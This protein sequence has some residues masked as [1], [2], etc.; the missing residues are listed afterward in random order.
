MR[1]KWLPIVLMVLG[2]AVLAADWWSAYPKGRTA[3]YVGRQACIQC[4]RQQV[5]QWTG[6]DHDLAMDRAG[7]ETIL[8]NFSDQEFTFNGITSRMYRN[9]EEF[10]ITTDGPSGE[11]ESFPIK[12]TFGVRPLQQ[13][14]S[15]FDDGRVQ[16]LSIAW[17][18]AAKRW[19]HLYPDEMI[20]HQDELH[21]T[22]PAQN[23][24]YMCAECH[25]TNLRKNYDPASDTYR[26]TFSEIDVSCEACHG[27]ASIHIE[28]ANSRSLFWD[29]RYGKGL[30][31]LKGKDSKAQLDTCARCHSRRHLIYEGYQPGDE[32]LDYYGLELLDGELYY[33]D[34]QIRDEVYVYGS[35]LQSRMYREGVR[36]TDC[37]DPHSTRLLAQGNDLCTQCH[38]AGS[39][40]TP[41][42]H[43]HEATSR[44]A[45]CV[46]CHMPE[47]TYM[48]VDPRRDH[49]FGIPRPDMTA[50]LDTPNACNGCHT[51]QNAQWAQGHMVS[52]YG[53]EW[54]GQPSFGSVLAAARTGKPE[55]ERELIRLA[56]RPEVGSI[57]HATALV[58]L[59][60]YGTRRSANA[61]QQA[62][63]ERE[64]LVRAAA[65][66]SLQ[67]VPPEL[68]VDQLS[69]LL[70]DPVRL[71]RME[72][73][74]VLSRVA[75]ERLSRTD[76]TA[77]S[78]A[79]AEY[80]RGQLAVADRAPAHHNLANIY[81]NR[82]QLD[83]AEAS[84][85]T[86]LRL[87]PSFLPARHNLAM[88]YY[89]K[90]DYQGAERT[91][92]EVLEQAPDMADDHYSLGL[93]LSEQHRL[94]EAVV[95]LA[96]A[97]ELAPER[98]RIHYNYGLAL[99]RLDQPQQAERELRRA[100]KLEPNSSDFWHALAVLYRQQQDWRQALECVNELVRL[101]PD[102]PEWLRLGTELQQRSNRSNKP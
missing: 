30:A 97:A 64:P 16:V 5:Q 69:S 52:W 4:H 92:R 78:L 98:A 72:A 56:S 40:D 65:V 27:P 42:H 82:G 38:V 88:L 86:A 28:L 26:T 15:E 43:H 12:Y 45:G 87:A 74:R 68:A 51:D 93:L 14:M 96:K 36:C 7:P 63:A 60:Q 1:L 91:F 29:R 48:V 76:Q 32:F 20:D 85:R 54:K 21:W 10:F 89:Q 66:R 71:V 23:W 59:E 41:A 57:V 70:K 37:H 53:P 6:S 99:Q 18:T 44:G 11:L 50:L 62:L 58:L 81:A 24:N 47:R 33:P 17:D 90:E 102:N 9:G 19:F 25:S 83:R 22:K 75:P 67:N 84:Y 77:L 8:G 13:Y 3:S 49:R 61:R 79:L 31:R 35:F 101:Q 100:A 80:Q 2:G 55:A 46:E 94:P 39:Y 95:H 73:A 34:G